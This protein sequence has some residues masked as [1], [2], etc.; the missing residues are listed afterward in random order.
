M[1][2]PWDIVEHHQFGGLGIITNVECDG[3]LAPL[4]GVTWIVAPDPSPLHGW[5]Y[6][7]RHPAYDFRTNAKA[8]VRLGKVV[9]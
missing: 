8:L 7:E 6:R 4:L 3:R 2:K 9:L 5:F 1:I